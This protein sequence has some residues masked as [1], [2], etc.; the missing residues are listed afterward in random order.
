MERITGVVHQQ[1]Q[2]LSATGALQNELVSHTTTR[3]VVLETIVSTCCALNN[4]LEG[5][6]P[7]S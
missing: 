5:I 1:L 4:V 2:I 3:G 7:F 6:V